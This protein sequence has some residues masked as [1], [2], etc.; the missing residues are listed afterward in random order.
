MTRHLR[1]GLIAAV[2]VLVLDQLTK[3]WL[4]HGFDLAHRGAVTVTPFF[5]LVLAWNP[6]ISFGWF[7]SNGP[8]RPDHPD[9][10]QGGGGD[11]AGDLDGAV[12]DAA[13]HRWRSA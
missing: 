12:A 6:G 11:R 4:L 13:G 5:D 9:D 8:G 3:L 2:T 10:R 1:P 7:Q